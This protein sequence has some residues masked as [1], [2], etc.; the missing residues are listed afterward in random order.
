MEDSLSAVHTNN[1][2]HT[3]EHSRDMLSTEIVTRAVRGSTTSWSGMNH[4]Q[5]VS[6]TASCTQT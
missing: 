4:C 5:L 1:A 6:F 2:L 3:A